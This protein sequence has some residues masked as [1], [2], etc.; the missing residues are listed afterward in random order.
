MN[1]LK[2]AV[3]QLVK[4]PGFTA[5][6]VVVLALGIAGNIV[7]FS[8]FNSFFLRP[9][10]FQDADRLVDLDETAPRWNLEFTGLSYPNFDSWR[11]DS[12]FFDGVGAWSGASYNLSSRSGVQRVNGLRVTHDLGAALGLKPALGRFITLEEDR[13]GGAKVVVLGHGLWQRLFGGADVV[14][15][16]LRLD[17]DAYTI[18][19]VLPPN[20]AML[21][22]AE[23]WVPL[24]ESPDSKDN[25][26]LSGVGRLKRGVDLAQ[27]REELRRIHRSLV[28]QHKASENTFPKVTPL[29]ERYFG[30]GRL[31]IDVLLVAAMLVLLVAC[32]NVAALMLARGLARSRE[33]GVRRALGATR[34][35]VA[36]LIGTEAL[37]VSSLGGVLGACL[38]FWGLRTLLAA[39]G[40]MIPTWVHFNY[41]WRVGLFVAA[42]VLAAAG[43]GALPTIRAAL[44]TS[45]QAA[46]QSSTQQSTVSGSKRQALNALVVAELA[47]TVVVT[48]QAGLLVQ[49][50]RW[51]QRADPGYRPANV[52]TFELALPG[53]RYGSPEAQTEFFRNHLEQVRHLPGVTAASAVSAPPLG[54]HWGTFFEVENAAPKGPNDPDPVVLQR[55]SLPGYLE[56]MGIR[57]LKGR[58]FTDRD[59]LN[60]GSSA[61]IVNDLF[62]Q[63]FWS[64]QEPLGKRI[65]PRGASAPWM[66]VVGV[67]RDVKHYGLDRP[68]IPGVYLPYAQRPVPQMTVV[69]RTSAS[70]ATIIPPIQS[71]LR[72]SDPELPMFS[73]TTLEERLTRSIWLRRLYSVLI[74]TSWQERPCSWPSGES[75][76]SSPTSWAAVAERLRSAWRSVPRRAGS[77][78]W[79]CDKACS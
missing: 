64:N 73:V 8:F 47:I 39:L 4:N 74:S 55:I 66:T 7:A 13:P 26:Y 5:V 46:L 27:V 20:T 28:D 44:G 41:D 38:G 21:E 29:S 77:D 62:V 57:L 1:D 49:T 67:V 71:L 22:R 34:W 24:A 59:G 2:F 50:F 25:W 69:V 61:V 63:Q 53:N 15:Q 11:R 58:T 16:T 45:P 18:V 35:S 36:R 19:G 30:P 31:V 52:V 33:F 60:E 32:G 23:F 40:G 12:R 78:G 65:R 37:V 56:T 70:P 17:Q 48:V 43:L 54:A 10:P 72:Q 68:M 51:L 75:S 6:A 3:R 9:F 76:A 42:I 14:G 79:C